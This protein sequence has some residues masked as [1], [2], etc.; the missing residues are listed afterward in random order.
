MKKCEE[1]GFYFVLKDKKGQFY[2]RFVKTMH[3]GLDLKFNEDKQHVD[4]LHQFSIWGIT[5]L[6]LNY[7][8]R[9]NELILLLN[10]NKI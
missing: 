1:S 8:L 2:G 5:F 7:R 6:K 3:D 10:Q 9:K 4:A